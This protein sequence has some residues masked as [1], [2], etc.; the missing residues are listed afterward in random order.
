MSFQQKAYIFDLD[1]FNAGLRPLVEESLR[2]ND[3]A[4]L[5]RF[6]AQH[7]DELKDPY[8]GEPL[9]SNWEG[10]LETRD[11]QEYADFA[12]TLYYDPSADIG[13][14]N[15]WPALQELLVREAPAGTD[16]TMGDVVGPPSRPFDPGGMG[17][18]FLTN[19]AAVSRLET[20]RELSGERTNLR[21]QIAPLLELF[22][23]IVDSGR[24][25]YVT[26]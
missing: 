21:D 26:F 6:I 16:L 15:G 5:R 20:L 25:A 7:L 12:L 14:G 1:R 10:L 11:V 9:E 23:T 17:A 2:T 22:A 19:E 4:A 18:F 3:H 8:A 24:G 13:L